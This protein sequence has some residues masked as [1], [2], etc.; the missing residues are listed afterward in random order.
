[1]K[2]KRIP[3]VF[4]EPSRSSYE[5]ANSLSKNSSI[6]IPDG[7]DGLNVFPF[8]RKGHLVTTFEPDVLFIEGE[9]ILNPHSIYGLN[10]R[11]E[12]TDYKE[13]IRIENKNFYTSKAYKKYDHVFVYKSLHRECNNIVSLK[14]KINKL[15]RAVNENGSIYIY[16]YL[17]IDDQ[18]NV[19]SYPKYD[20]IKSY[21]SDKE[22]IIKSSKEFVSVIQDKSYYNDDKDSFHK[23][24][25][26]HAKRKPVKH[27]YRFN[28]SIGLKY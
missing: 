21:F 15:M 26:I 4:G 7:Y 1:M 20:E 6:L 3:S 24:G 22:W 14:Y 17:P 5:I 16:Y 10:K 13:N 9:E 28:I 11:I 19:N 8:L 18:Y 25:Y 23:I 12:I 2:T 27:I